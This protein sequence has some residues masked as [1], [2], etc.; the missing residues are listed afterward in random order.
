MLGVRLGEALLAAG[1]I[2]EQQLTQ[3]LEIQ[4]KSGARLGEILVSLGALHHLE[5]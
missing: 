4:T 3:A 5:L 2:T 1:S